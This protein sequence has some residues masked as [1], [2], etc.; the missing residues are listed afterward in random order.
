MTNSKIRCLLYAVSVSVGMA[1]IGAIQASAE[2][3][4]VIPTPNLPAPGCAHIY[5]KIQDAVDAAA[6]GDTI[7][8]APGTYQ[9]DVTIPETT[10]VS[11]IGTNPANT[12]I[13]AMGKANGIFINGFINGVPPSYPG[14]TQIANTLRD[15]TVSGF[16]VK[17]ANFEG[18]L[19]T[20]ASYVTLWNNRVINNDRALALG[21]SACEPGSPQGFPAFETNENFDCGEGIHLSGV[22]HSTVADNVSENNAGGVLLSDDTGPTYHNLISGNTVADNPYDCGITL[23]SHDAYGNTGEPYGYGV[24]R[25]TIAGNTSTKNGTAIAGAGAGVGLFASAPGTQTYGNV[26][27][28]NRLTN[29]GL[30]GVAMHSHTPGQNL[31]DNVI[32]ENYISGN[33]PDSDVQSTLVPTGISLLAVTAN[34]GT[35]ISR[36]VIKNE[37]AAIAV[38]LASNSGSIVEAHL[39]DLLGSGSMGVENLAA[40]GVNATENWWGCGTGPNTNGCTSTTGNVLS[41]PYLSAPAH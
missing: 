35:V 23:A 17:N 18:I 20:N 33:G 12:I 31:N 29:N 2:T 4:C 28:K 25:N 40:G 10:P 15:V 34:T 8:V 21:P 22:D 5:T 19:V 1:A 30:P 38:N 32:T 27:I 16:T 36:N 37:G 14:P 9:E 7:K 3:L 39:N 11:L 41:A 26:V 24:Y 6:A 13:D